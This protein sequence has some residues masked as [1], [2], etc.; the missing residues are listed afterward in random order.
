MFSQFVKWTNYIRVYK[1]R[2]LCII[3][4]EDLFQP[5]IQS[6]LELILGKPLVGFP[7]SYIPP[8][9]TFITPTEEE[10]K[11]FVK[12]KHWIDYVNR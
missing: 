12:Y 8:K 3:K 9:S 6:K 5:T 2:N 4:Y 7:I 11:L 10:E 1:P